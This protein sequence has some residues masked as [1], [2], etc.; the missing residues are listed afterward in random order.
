M[1][2]LLVP[3]LSIFPSSLSPSEY[4]AYIMLFGQIPW[5]NVIQ[6]M[7][8]FEIW[9]KTTKVDWIPIGHKKKRIKVPL[10]K[11]AHFLKT[12]RI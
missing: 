5:T 6:E 2:L 11:A 4:S 8:D 9:P 10:S 1:F 3:N 12:E 7:T